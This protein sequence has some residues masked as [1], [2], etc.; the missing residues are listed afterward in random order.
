MTCPRAHC[1]GLLFEDEGEWVCK[2]CSRRWTD[3]TLNLER[4]RMPAPK[5]KPS[6][7]DEA[8][9]DRRL[10]DLLRDEEDGDEE[11]EEGT[12]MAERCQKPRGRG[13]CK[14]DAVPGSNFCRDCG[15]TPKPEARSPKP[16][17]RSPKPEARREEGDPR[18][19]RRL[20]AALTRPRQLQTAMA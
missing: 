13:R 6:A 20:R 7:I 4:A 2:S 19:H 15:G 16:E 17:A 10:N 9:L 8:M 14:A 12:I 5:T 1:G 3:E 18:G 11:P